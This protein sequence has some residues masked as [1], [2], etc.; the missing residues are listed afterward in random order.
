[1]ILQVWAQA[2]KSEPSA[3]MIAEGTFQEVFR[4]AARLFGDPQGDHGIR[5]LRFLAP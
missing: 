1:M 4:A 2:C 3:P 5:S